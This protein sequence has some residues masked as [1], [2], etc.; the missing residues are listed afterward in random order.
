MNYGRMFARMRRDTLCGIFMFPPKL[1]T[2]NTNM[3]KLSAIPT[4]TLRNQ[5]R[6]AKSAWES[7]GNGVDRVGRSVVA[8]ETFQHRGDKSGLRFDGFH[9]RRGR[10]G[11]RDEWMWRRCSIAG[12]GRMENFDRRNLV[13][14]Y[15]DECIFHSNDDQQFF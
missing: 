10:R 6:R 1:R 12:N 15:H 7:R 9:Q 14:V 13:R 2:I 5:N 8:G 11:R 3:A 4:A